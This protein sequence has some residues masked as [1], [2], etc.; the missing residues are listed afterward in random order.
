MN[1][2]SLKNL[3][4]G[5]TDLI[6][7][8]VFCKKEIKKPFIKKHVEAC[9]KN[10]SFGTPC[11]NCNCLKHPNKKTCSTSCYNS[12]YRK[13]R[14]NPNYQGNNY[15]TVC[16]SY[17]KKEC[18][19]CGFNL[20]VDV[21]HLNGNNQ[22]NRPSNLIPLCPN[23]HRVWHSR[24]CHLIK[25]KVLDYASCFGASPNLVMAP[26]LGTGIISVQI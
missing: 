5:R 12:L 23:H 22:D 8:C 16:F 7:C 2:N 15:R 3:L 19:I 10:P 9:P 13:G 11:P 17:H 1:Q 20:I 21:H 26:V 25:Q 6:V 4:R 24:H 14:L 18:C